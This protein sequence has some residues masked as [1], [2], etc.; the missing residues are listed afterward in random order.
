MDQTG[1]HHQLLTMD[2]L[3]QLMDPSLYKH[4]QRT[5]SFNLFF[6]FR[7]LLVWFK[8]EFSWDDT[9]T[10]WEVLWT[11]YLTDHFH[12]FIALSIL[13][14]HRDVMIDYLQNFDEILKVQVSLPPPLFFSMD[15]HDFGSLVDAFFLVH[16]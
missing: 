14:Q 6:C 10:L 15:R 16:Q 3:I 2:V 5:D 7:W 1:M 4:L 11:N 13:D 12:L 8:R 9:L